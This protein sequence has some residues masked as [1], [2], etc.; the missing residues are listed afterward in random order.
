MYNE[1]E[2]GGLRMTD[3]AVYID[4]QLAHWTKKLLQ[5]KDSVPFSFIS[6]LLHMDMIDF[7]KCNFDSS[8][9]P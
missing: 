5:N 2:N 9:F 8:S 3:I 7:L 1:Y 4:A 6:S